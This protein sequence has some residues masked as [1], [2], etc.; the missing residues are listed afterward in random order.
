MFAGEYCA[1]LRGILRIL[2]DFADFVG[3]LCVFSVLLWFGGILSVF[4][5]FFGF[6]GCLGFSG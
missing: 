3:N 2:R 1:V 4:G 5:C 6:S